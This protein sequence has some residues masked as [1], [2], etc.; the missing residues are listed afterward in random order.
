MNDMI[1]HAL[2]FITERVDAHLTSNSS[3]PYFVALNGVQG[4][5]KTT[6]VS[7]YETLCTEFASV[8]L[9]FARPS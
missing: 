5:G 4:A 7:H 1:D 2:A 8:S 3:E 6:L 9:L